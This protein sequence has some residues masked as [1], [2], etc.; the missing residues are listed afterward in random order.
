VALT[1]GTRLGPYEIAAP[2]GAG[3]MGEVYRATDTRLDRP[4]AVKVAV[5][6][7]TER[8]G[9]EARAISSL[10]H[11]NICTLY[12]VGSLPSG[13]GYLVMELLEGETLARHIARG[14]LPLRRVLEFGAQMAGALAAAHARGI[15]HRDLKPGN[16]VV[17]KHGV[18]V[19]DFGLARVD[20]AP[21]STIDAS[22]RAAPLTDRHTV[23][24]TRPYMSPEQVQGKE[25]DARSDIFSFGVVLY[26]MITGTRP[27]DGDNSTA[28]SA[29]ILKDEPKPIGDTLPGTP[30]S[31]EHVLRKCLE[32]DPADRWQSAQDLASALALVEFDGSTVS[33]GVGRPA[34][35]GRERSW[36]RIAAL[37]G[38]VGV[39][40][41]ALW[42]LWPSPAPP[43]EVRRFEVMLPQDATVVPGVFYASLSPDG[44]TLAFTT[45]GPNGGIWVRDLSTLTS[46]LLPETQNVIG[47]TWA[48]DSRSIAFGRA[49]DLF[50]VD[51]GGGRPTLIATSPDPVGSGFW[52]ADG[53]I[54]FGGR[55]RGPLRR[56]SASGG[57]PVLVTSLDP[58]R[59]E[60]SHLLPSLLPDG[61]HFLYLR[62]SSAASL[63]GVYVGD[64][65]AA[66]EEQ[67]T[68][69]VLP[70]AVGV[71]YVPPAGDWP[72]YVLFHG[73]PP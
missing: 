29:A 23:L 43:P 48:P 44:S 52:T 27:F 59:G 42:A 58:E 72:G 54:V 69:L 35:A 61:Q 34:P 37:T 50:R 62:A 4:V 39:A 13:A 25:A 56:V 26:E 65:D 33:S 38:A 28:L 21:A 53:E 17:T 63:D 46:T 5:E 60:N 51:L 70:S 49:Y 67:L 8:F 31:V 73:T 20:V 18:K 68:E 41:L 66:P 24:G 1:P 10:S 9:R 3:G 2:L 47:L 11:P 32:K 14:P 57:E 15:V 7:F 40:A 6:E 45:V 71:H 30:R 12:D 55:G 64:L 22:T 36:T 16:V 19:L